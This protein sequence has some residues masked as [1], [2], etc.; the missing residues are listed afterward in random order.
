VLYNGL[1]IGYTIGNDMSSRTI[2]GENPLYLPQA[3][4]YSR[5][6]AI[7]PAFVTPET[8]GNPRNL[9]VE[10]SILRTAEEIF[11]GRTS[12]SLMARTCEELADWLFA[13]NDVPNMT[14]VLTG[15]AKVP[16]PDITLKEDDVV[17]MTIENIGTLE[18]Y[19][20]VV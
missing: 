8:V 2:E 11:R 6:C 7:G 18:N 14:A 17:V 5:C 12:T 10:Y 9:S 4:M 16:P 19:V 13:S 20:T 1:I 15:T 3:K